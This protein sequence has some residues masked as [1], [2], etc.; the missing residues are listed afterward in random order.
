MRAA[1]VG[2]YIAAYRRYCWPVESLADYRLAPFHLLA[3][4]GAVHSDKDH[5]WHMQM[6]ARLAHHPLL[7]ATAYIQVDVTD[8]ASTEAG[9]AWWEGTHRARRAKGWW[10][11]RWRL[12][13][14]ASAG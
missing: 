9:V 12:S 14:P 2:D 13:P 8:P 7:T 4:E 3:S 10:S 5:R 1:M 6:L 11:S